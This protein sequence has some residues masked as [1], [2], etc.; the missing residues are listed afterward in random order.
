M[1]S[2]RFVPRA[3][4]AAVG[5]LAAAGGLV[6]AGGPALA[7]PVLGGQL[8]GTGG[9]VTVEVLPATS[10]FTSELRLCQP[11]EPQ[12]FLALDSDVGS[13]VTVGTFPA[14][15]EL[16]FCIF[17]R[18]TGQ[19]YYMGPAS[20]NP[21]NVLHATVDATGPGAAIVGFEDLFG[22]GD[23]DYDDNVF[24]FTGV[25][26]NPPPDCSG[27]TASSS[28]LWPPNG[29]MQQITLSGATDPQGEAVTI[30]VTGVTQDEALSSDADAQAGPT[31]NSV[32]LRS[33]RE[34]GGDGRV[35]V[36]SYEATDASGGTCTGTVT[37]TVPHDQSGAAAVD[38]GQTV[39]SFGS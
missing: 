38:S 8:F 24:K 16:V 1:R 21:D 33:K 10:G 12:Q 2:R 22:G 14:G 26:P 28:T 37:V 7:A 35:Y 36:I 39:N 15:V 27:V 30:E 5:V 19:T 32:L 20:R 31:S 6:V 3:F 29:K 4:A 17:V 23:R 34:G 25:I 11:G 13:V 9:E 18:N